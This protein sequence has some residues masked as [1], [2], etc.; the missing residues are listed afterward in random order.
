M[1]QNGSFVNRFHPISGV[2]ARDRLRRIKMRGIS[3]WDSREAAC[4]KNF[5]LR[6]ILTSVAAFGNIRREIGGWENRL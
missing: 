4:A 6:R 1:V 2:D 5:L 3:P